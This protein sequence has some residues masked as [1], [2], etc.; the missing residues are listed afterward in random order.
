MGKFIRLTP[1]TRVFLVGQGWRAVRTTDPEES[2]ELHKTT[3]QTISW[4]CRT[5][6]LTRLAMYDVNKSTMFYI[7]MVRFLPWVSIK[8]LSILSWFR[9]EK[10]TENG[11]E[12]FKK[13]QLYMEQQMCIIWRWQ[14]KYV[15]IVDHLTNVW[16]LIKTW[17]RDNIF[18]SYIDCY[19]N[20]VD[21]IWCYLLE[22][23]Y[24]D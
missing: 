17:E 10:S 22:D 7:K 18:I 12:K 6:P 24:L 13:E 20:L 15:Q 4:D 5:F 1:L 23:F 3:K 19:A 8:L 16:Y 14:F 9:E 2:P 11:T 21:N